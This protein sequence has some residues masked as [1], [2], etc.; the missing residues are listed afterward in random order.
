MHISNLNL[1]PQINLQTAGGAG[2]LLGQ[3]IHLQWCQLN[4]IRM[5]GPAAAS[6]Y[7]GKH[8]QARIASIPV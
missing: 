2:L 6:P 3:T 5:H 8:Y 4:P 1:T 7:H